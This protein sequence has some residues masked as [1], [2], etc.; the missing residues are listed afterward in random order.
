MLII[1]TI[2]I[3]IVI[4]GGLGGDLP[5]EAVPLLGLLLV[6]RAQAVPTYIYIYIY[7]YI[8]IWICIISTP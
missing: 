3:V 6:Q 4:R 8:C 2:I 5:A 1:I 7:I